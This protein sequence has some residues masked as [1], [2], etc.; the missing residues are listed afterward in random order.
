MSKAIVYTDGGARPTNPGHA[1]IGIHIEFEDRD[2]QQLSRYVGWKSNNEA[3]YLALIVAL[4]YA[5]FLNVTDVEVR[6]DSKLVVKQVTGEWYPKDDRMRAFCR[7][8]QDR[9]EKV[10]RGAVQ[11][12]QIPREQNTEADKLA[13]EA[14]QWGRAQNPYVSRALSIPAGNVVDPFDMNSRMSIR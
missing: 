11:L 3:E 14:A 2:P 12:K 1:G 4:G 5:H 10:Y 9:I 6:C 13:T 7:T 8:A